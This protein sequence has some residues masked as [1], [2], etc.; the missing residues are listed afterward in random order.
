MV[1]KKD[2]KIKLQ[3]FYD[4]MLSSFEVIDWVPLMKEFIREF[5][6]FF[7]GYLWL[8]TNCLQHISKD[9]TMKR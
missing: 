9:E 6:L 3:P 8:L 5:D 2:K 1:D 4:G 7:L